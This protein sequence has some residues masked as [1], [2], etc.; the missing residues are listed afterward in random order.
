MK[1]IEATV[2]E[3]QYLVGAGFRSTNWSQINLLRGLCRTPFRQPSMVRGCVHWVN[4]FGVHRV[5]QK[6]GAEPNQ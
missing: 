4:L 6:P 2:G 3:M 5:P 1:S